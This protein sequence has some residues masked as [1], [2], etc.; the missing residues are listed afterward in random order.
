LFQNTRITNEDFLKF[1]KTRI[2][3]YRSFWAT[4]SVSEQFGGVATYSRKSVPVALDL[5]S[6]PKKFYHCSHNYQPVCPL[7]NHPIYSILGRTMITDHDEFVLVNLFFPPHFQQGHKQMAR[8]RLQQQLYD[9]TKQLLAAKRNVVLAGDFNF[10]PEERDMSNPSAARYTLFE[11]DRQWFQAMKELGFRDC[12]RSLHPGAQY[13]S[14]T[15]KFIFPNIAETDMRTS[16]VLANREFMEKH[17]RDC[18]YLDFRTLKYPDP[19]SRIKIT[20]NENKDSTQE[21]ESK[22]RKE[23]QKIRNVTRTMEFSHQPIVLVTDIE[24]L[25]SPI[26]SQQSL[27]GISEN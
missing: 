2:D 21:T 11:N 22:G 26:P 13:Y 24:P 5:T 10:P 1:P 25:E 23:K 7:P 19:S 17:V 3:F 14:T 20:K 15:S 12:Y 18:F 4:S 27:S 6:Q 8:Y 9:F 16:L